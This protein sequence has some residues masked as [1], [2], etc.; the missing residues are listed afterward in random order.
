[1]GLGLRHLQDKL[2]KWGI[3]YFRAEELCRFPRWGEV[4]A[5]PIKLQRNIRPTVEFADEL[6]RQF[7]A[8][9]RC[10]NGYRN[11]LYNRE[12]GG[13]PQ[14]EHL[15]FRA[16][17]IQPLEYT[18][19]AMERLRALAVEL[20]EECEGDVRI[21][22]YDKF[23]HVDFGAADWKTRDPEKLDNRTRR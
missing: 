13:A 6:R 11:Y 19:P 12:V 15:S 10:I 8:A 22:Q 4:S 14:S 16:M 2:D 17:D 23:I 20:A 5:P 9:I 1:M 3:E 7:G 18:Q 21:L